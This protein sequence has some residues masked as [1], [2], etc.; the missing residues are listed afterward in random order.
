MK[1]QDRIFFKQILKPVIVHLT[2]IADEAF[3]KEITNAPRKIFSSADMWN[4]Q[5]R[6]R[7]LVI[8]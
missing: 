2:N 4:I 3:V 1:M 5:R 8:R 6:R 7:S